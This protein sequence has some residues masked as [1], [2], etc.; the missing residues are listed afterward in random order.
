MTTMQHV[1][2]QALNDLL[3]KHMLARQRRRLGR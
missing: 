2:C 3:E 1:L